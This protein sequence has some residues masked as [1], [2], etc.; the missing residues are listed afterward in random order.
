ML[1]Q[2]DSHRE[3]RQVVAE[4]VAENRTRSPLAHPG[5]TQQSWGETKSLFRFLSRVCTLTLHL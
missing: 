4:R 1:R 5:Q 2:G 3:N